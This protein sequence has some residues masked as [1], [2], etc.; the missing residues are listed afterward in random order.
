MIDGSAALG[1]YYSYSNAK[2]SILHPTGTRLICHSWHNQGLAKLTPIVDFIMQH[3]H[4]PIYPRGLPALEPEL[5]PL[6]DQHQAQLSA[7]IQAH[8][9]FLPYDQWMQAA[10]YAPHFGYYTGGSTKFHTAGDF[11][12]APEI[13][14]LFGQTLANQ[15]QQILQQCAGTTILEFGAGSGALAE[16]ILVSLNQLGLPNIQYCILELSPTLRQRQQARL[17]PFAKQVQW[18]ETLPSAFTG[19]VI[20]NE[21]LDAMPI[22]LVQ[23]DQ[24]GA[25]LELGVGLN[26]DTSASAP[27]PFVLL[28]RPAS[29]ELA[30]LAD[31]RLPDL[32]GYR[33]EINLHAESWIQAMGQWLK[34]G[35]A[36]LIDYG[37]SQREYYHP[38]R[39]M[40][41]L[42]CHFRHF[43]HDESLILP[44]FQ[45]ITAHVDFTA[46]ADAAIAA[47]LDVLGYASQAHFLL[48]SGLPQ[49]LEQLQTQLD[50]QQPAHLQSWTQQVSAVQKLLSEAE[51]GELFKVMAIGKHI[52][53]PLLGFT[54]RD[55]RDYL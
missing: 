10:L 38:Q 16:S 49:H 41:T 14:P 33:S 23:R 32:A 1:E 42:M 13:T 11:T 24:N 43:A 36:L 20:A 52:E 5:L 51:M 2:L 4:T 25:I 44:G 6:L 40:G 21:V 53:P 50:M 45:D 27:S 54:A 46:I 35:A 12:T 55:R 19:C 15:V 29:T 30:Q 48:N 34:K 17:A 18:L 8:Q 28:G 37:F 39:H 31:S 26:T 47:Q 3:L 22:H 9:G 7:L